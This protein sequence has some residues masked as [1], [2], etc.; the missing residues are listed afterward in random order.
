MKDSELLE[1]ANLKCYCEFD[2]FGVETS[3]Y[4]LSDSLN[5]PSDE[6]RIERLKILIDE[7]FQDKLVIS[8]DIHTKH[9]LVS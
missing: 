4:E 6:T 3:Y 9:R 5:M 8:H 1:F 2:L 7:G